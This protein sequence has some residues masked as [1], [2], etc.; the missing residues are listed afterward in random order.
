MCR[1]QDFVDFFVVWGSVEED[2]GYDPQR[3]NAFEVIELFTIT[4][5][6]AQCLAVD[7]YQSLSVAVF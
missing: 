5:F 7:V 6:L 2:A 3:G 1:K 4:V